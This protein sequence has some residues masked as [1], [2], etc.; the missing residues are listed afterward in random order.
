MAYKD[1]YAGQHGRYDSHYTDAPDFNPYNNA[2]PH[3]AYDQGG[4]DSYAAPA[5]YMDDANNGQSSN[6]GKRKIESTQYNQGAFARGTTGKCVSPF[7][8]P[9]SEQGAEMLV[10]Y[11]RFPD[12]RHWRYEHHR[13]LWGK[14][15]T[16]AASSMATGAQALNLLT[17]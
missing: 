9:F 7:V 14:V 17:G 8:E 16:A 3:Q 1:P 13:G 4:Y 11:R 5:G 12:L 6:P 2:Q 10:S 15:R